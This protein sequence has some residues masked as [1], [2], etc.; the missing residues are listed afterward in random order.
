MLEDEGCEQEQ[1]WTVL[2]RKGSVLGWEKNTVPVTE[3]LCL[4]PAQGTVA[5]VTRNSIR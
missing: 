2:K 5:R 4:C 3:A 1:G